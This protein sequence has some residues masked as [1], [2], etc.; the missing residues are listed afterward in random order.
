[1]ASDLELRR[2]IIMN[3]YVWQYNN[4]KLNSNFNQDNF[5]LLFKNKKEAEKTWKSYK[6]ELETLKEEKK[7]LVKNIQ[8]ITYFFTNQIQESDL[9]E[10]I[11][12]KVYSKYL[13][14]IYENK[15]IQSHPDIEFEFLLRKNRAIFDDTFVRNIV[16]HID[17]FDY[18]VGDIFKHEVLGT[19]TSKELSTGCK[20]MILYYYKDDYIINLSQ[21]GDNCSSIFTAITKKK[22]KENRRCIVQTQHCFDLQQEVFPIYSRFSNKLLNNYMDFL[23]DYDKWS[24][25]YYG[26]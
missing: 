17:E 24:T 4:G 15:A 2:K 3:M 13:N 26:E 25:D 6:E 9:L 5:N 19:I 18:V 21:C 20:T 16:K 22:L 12:N 7:I 8:G 1:M 10:F 11:N 23:L 14:L